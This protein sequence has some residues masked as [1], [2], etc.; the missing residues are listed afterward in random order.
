MLEKFLYVTIDPDAKNKHK[1]QIAA[2]LDKVRNPRLFCN[3]P[4]STTTSLSGG[5]PLL[6]DFRYFGNSLMGII[7]ILTFF[8]I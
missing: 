6:K 7:F 1:A 8:N 3:D 4:I 5:V 2:K